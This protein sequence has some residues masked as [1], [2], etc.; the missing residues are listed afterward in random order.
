M[1]SV[2]TSVDTEFAA[3]YPQVSAR[4]SAPTSIHRSED[5]QQPVTV[6]RPTSTWQ[7]INVAELWK[8]RELCGFLVWRDVKV[9]YKQT[10]LGV[11][12][13]ILQPLLL[14]VVFTVFF[15]RMA[16]VDSG[17]MPYPLF[18][19]S[20]LL[21]WVFFSTAIANAGNSVVGSERL[22]TKIYFPRLS[23]P[24]AAVGAAFVD[25]VIAFGM[26][27]VLMIWYGVVPNA[28]IFAVPF[29]IVIIA[30]AALGVG[31]LL[32]ALNVAYRDFRYVIPFLV[33]LWMFATPTIY[34]QPANYS[35]E[36][37][38]T[39]SQTGDW[40]S[41]SAPHA[42]IERANEGALPAHIQALLNINPLVGLIAF[43]RAAMLGGPLPWA[44]A[45]WSA[46]SAILMFVV[47][48]LYFRHVEDSFA[49]II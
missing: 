43:F 27:I 20:G 21:P 48:C 35:V 25:F 42:S 32:A 6:I 22:I 15:G 30:M 37:A 9:R 18:A 46:L 2:Q 1:K 40:N 11:A 10:L 49:D 41:R 16:G 7:V 31:T 33:Q 38:S 34:M 24:F 39:E 5:L 29:V 36:F 23:I 45:C 14:M 47:G 12:W 28:S 8:Y 19:F 17:G 3:D 4:A 26:L 13:A 44:T